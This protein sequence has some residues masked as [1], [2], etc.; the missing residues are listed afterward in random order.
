MYNP[1][2]LTVTNLDVPEESNEGDMVLISEVPEMPNIQA[3]IQGFPSSDEAE[4]SLAIRYIVNTPIAGTSWTKI[5]N[6]ETFIPDPENT[7]KTFSGAHEWKLQDENEYD[8]V[9]MGGEATFYYRLDPSDPIEEM[10][11]KVL[12][13][14]PDD[15][16]VLTYIS[17]VKGTYWFADAIAR[18]ESVSAGEVFSQFNP[19]TSAESVAGLPNY[20]GPDGWGI[21]QLDGNGLGR[22]ITIE[23][24]WNW[25]TNIDHGI[26]VI[27]SKVAALNEYVDAMQ[28]IYPNEFEDPRTPNLYTHSVTVNGDTKVLTFDEASIIQRYNTGRGIYD[29]W[30][31]DGN[32]DPV[33]IRSF[34]YAWEFIPSAPAGSRW[35]F[36]ANTN[37]YVQEVMEEH[38]ALYG[39]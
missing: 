8:D 29:E 31:T 2:K 34:A 21:M 14:N 24:L 6:D 25:K 28:R 39:F 17:T 10:S 5:R 37:G 9:F 22:D 19:L 11:I 36:G 26:D 33:I 30:G 1:P 15:A 3:K 13:D 27:D 38:H 20:G 12:G 7:F 23:E 4:M 16:D 32:G 18:H 35:V